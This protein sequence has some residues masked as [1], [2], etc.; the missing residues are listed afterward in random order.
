MIEEM[1]TLIKNKTWRSIIRTKWVFKTKYKEDGVIERCRAGLVS[2][3]NIQTQGVDSD[4]TYAPVVQIFL[5]YNR[6]NWSIHHNLIEIAAAYLS[7][8][9][10]EDVYR[11]MAK[12]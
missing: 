4:Q 10:D 1:K 8:D 3:G 6:D 9:L 2:L 5:H 7:T 12:E 11:K